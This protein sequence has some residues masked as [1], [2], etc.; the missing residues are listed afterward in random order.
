MAEVLGLPT[1]RILAWARRGLVNPQRG[2]DGAYVFSFQ[3]VA[4]LRRVRALLDEDLPPR[5]LQAALDALR[6]Q[7]PV[8]RPLS[9]LDLSVHGRRVLVRDGDATWEPDTGQLRLDLDAPPVPAAA[10]LAGAVR[11]LGLPAGERAI[12]DAHPD[13]D[14]DVDLDPEASDDWYDAALDL[15]TSDPRGAAEAYRRAIELDPGHADALLNLGRL[16]HEEGRVDEA[17]AR[18]RDALDADPSSARAWFNLGVALEDLGR[19][20]DAV[21]A[22]ERALKLDDQLAVAHFN[23]SRLLDETGL[24]AKALRHLA[25]YR[26][27]AA[28]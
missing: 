1:S 17:E 19:R 22:Y 24:R 5:R 6:G 18:Y 13:P 10:A 3:D 16:L 21:R 4:L 7:L 15:E 12:P 25:R 8:G 11:V 23:L 14:P 2:D 26:Q 27:L 28:R 20:D 9:A